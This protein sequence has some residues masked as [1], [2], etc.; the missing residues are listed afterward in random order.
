MNIKYLLFKYSPWYSLASV[1][2]WVFGLFTKANTFFICYHPLFTVSCICQLPHPSLA[3]T[4]QAPS[5]QVALV[6][7]P[8]PRKGPVLHFWNILLFYDIRAM[9]ARR[10]KSVLWVAGNQRFPP[11]NF[12]I[13][14]Y[15]TILTNVALNKLSQRVLDLSLAL[16]TLDTGFQVPDQNLIALVE[17]RPDPDSYQTSGLSWW[18]SRFI[19]IHNPHTQVIPQLVISATCDSPF[20]TRN[21]DN[22][23]RHISLFRMQLRDLWYHT[24]EVILVTVYSSVCLKWMG[25][26][27]WANRSRVTFLPSVSP[28]GGGRQ[29][30]FSGPRPQAYIY[31][32]AWPW[33]RHWQKSQN[34]CS[35]QKYALAA[36]H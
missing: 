6:H 11:I 36:M 3:N 17:K 32:W 31:M 8:P 1:S 22:I 24:T 28:I 23:T 30:L 14:S 7:R 4:I 25:G 16:I 9:S 2:S 5:K 34:Q 35:R 21:R 27:T 19:S 15:F 29:L 33:K 26:A 20:T 10:H 18:T 13:L 12:F